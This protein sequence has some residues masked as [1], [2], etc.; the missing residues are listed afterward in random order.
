[1]EKYSNWSEL[2]VV[3]LLANALGGGGD[4]GRSFPYSDVEDLSRGLRFI[5]GEVTLARRRGERVEFVQ[6]CSHSCCWYWL[7]PDA[8]RSYYW[9]RGD[10]EVIAK[11]NSR[12]LG[13]VDGAGP[14]PLCSN[15]HTNGGRVKGENYDTD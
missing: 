1:M 14:C 11:Q 13:E 9:D 2:A 4:T 6:Q 12:N 10:Y 8:S 15:P 5:P 7:F 3:G